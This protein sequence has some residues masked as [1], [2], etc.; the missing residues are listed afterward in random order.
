VYGLAGF[1]PDNI[2]W[3]KHIWANLVTTLTSSLMHLA[4][5]QLSVPATLAVAVGFAI[6]NF[7]FQIS[8]SLDVVIVA[9]ISLNLISS[10]SGS[11]FAITSPAMVIG[12]LVL[13]IPASLVFVL[14]ARSYIRGQTGPPPRLWL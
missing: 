10:L 8:G 5:Y 9:H 12:P 2:T 14:V 7:A 4:V 1:D 13:V 6:L 11:T 3:G